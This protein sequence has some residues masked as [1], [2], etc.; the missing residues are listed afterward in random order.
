MASAGLYKMGS[1]EM[2]TS[3]GF[4]PRNLFRPNNGGAGHWHVAKKTT[5]DRRFRALI[6][7]ASDYTSNPDRK[8]ISASSRARTLETLCT[9]DSQEYILDDLFLMK[10]HYVDKPEDLCSVNVSCKN[11]TSARKEDF[12]QFECA[13]YI[14]ASDN[15]LALEDFTTF[16]A[17][18]ELDLSLNGIS[19]CHLNQ[20]DFPQLEVL[21]LSYN[22]LSPDDVMQ[23]SILPRLR[24]LHLTGNRLTHLP[25]DMSHSQR[26]DT[27]LVPFP[28]LEV[29]M[30]DDNRLSHPS[31]FGG[32]ANLKRLRQLNLSK[33]GVT[34]VPYLFEL[35]RAGPEER[36]GQKPTLA[37]STGCNKQHDKRGA[38]EDVRSDET[39]KDFDYIVLP[40]ADD[41]DRT[42]V[43]FTSAEPPHRDDD[44]DDLQEQLTTT[45]NPSFPSVFDLASMA[46]TDR[47]NQEFSPPLPNLRFLNLADNKIAHE[48][49]L[50]AVALFP[51][52]EELVI[53]GNPLTTLRKA[54]DSPLLKNF[55]QERLGIRV[56]QKKVPAP[57]KPHIVIPIREERKISTYIPKIPKHHLFMLE[58]AMNSYMG[59]LLGSSG[60]P[61][62]GLKEYRLCTS[63]LPP[64]K[65]SSKEV[66]DLS[67][68]K[69]CGSI[70][71]PE[72]AE[73]TGFG[74]DPS[75]ES[76]FMTQID[77]TCESL[78]TPCPMS[79]SPS[80]D[81]MAIDT[82][83]VGK[84]IPETFNGYEDFFDVQTDP[85]FIEPIGIQ[86]NVRAL[87][88]A[89]KRL[90][91]LQDFKPN[92]RDA[93]KP[94]A[95]TVNKVT[96]RDGECHSQTQ[97]GALPPAGAEVLYTDGI[98]PLVR[99]PDWLKQSGPKFD[100][101]A[102]L[103][104]R[105][106]KK[107]VMEDVLVNM[108]EQSHITQ[109]PL[110]LALQGKNSSEEQK[111]ARRLLSDL[112]QKYRSFYAST[113]KRA[114]ELESSLTATVKRLQETEQQLGNMEEKVKST[115][116]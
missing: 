112:Q 44:H 69:T 100:N 11:L 47:S 57:P 95:P 45:K 41:P 28:S 63:P 7:S 27:G 93:E 70:T 2:S 22:S 33:N 82:I 107:Q 83:V 46:H 15:G 35:D 20:E 101:G 75:V 8:K 14:N 50:L 103:S 78:H 17:L 97:A 85:K 108:R 87:E 105:K 12:M 19:S 114:N 24:V 99:H 66:K 1:G 39:E 25:P 13:A 109:E 60:G 64:I 116:L 88:N 32:L 58:P 52:L 91:I 94:C 104:P 79:P 18:R 26:E 56:I 30:L 81:R 68:R 21:D 48:E 4:P 65:S 51:S 54:A 74:S 72:E 16:P 40:N 110:E 73:K 29:L 90:L 36:A 9:L 38:S 5:P 102:H 106:T 55:F 31:V 84:D 3:N 42:D 111:K 115:K 62:G 113:V 53:H 10:T 89:L 71:I 61:G 96:R 98:G 23:L 77:E 67:P 43:L 80:D 76:V 49:N 59:V 37:G 6:C 34:E 92:R 86:G